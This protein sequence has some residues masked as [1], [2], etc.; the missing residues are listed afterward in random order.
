MS[1]TR[2]NDGPRLG[3]MLA[4]GAAPLGRYPGLVVTLY[5][6]QFA[7][8]ALA[9]W[10]MAFCL[11]AAFSRQPLFDQAVGGDIVAA[12]V[13]LRDNLALAAAVLATGLGA[14][15]TYAVVS[16]FL[17]GGLIAILIEKPVGR[18]NVAERFG[19][20]GASTFFAFARLWLW[21][22]IP[23]AASALLFAMGAA[24]AHDQVKSALT[25]GDVLAALLPALLPA[26]AIAWITSLAA[27][28]ARIAISLDRER[29]A[30]RALLAGYHLVA[31]RWRA[32][33]HALLF[34][35]AWIAITLLYL[36]VAG[37]RAMAGAGG[38]C[39]LF[40]LRQL[41]AILRFAVKIAFV[42]GQVELATSASQPRRA[43]ARLADN[44]VRA[45]A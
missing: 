5:A 40:G 42:G 7:V 32:P 20:A 35:L 23:Y 44:S 16:W 10:V 31:T 36:F 27:G 30:W 38:A 22:L 45:E 3:R 11:A 8:S 28:Y 24:H 39:L 19:A 33:A 17:A 13:L 18:R 15:A 25:F 34:G 4:A 29:P 26:A 41:T 37:D 12:L 14:V 1:A 21:C 43:A 2:R 6:V 9:G